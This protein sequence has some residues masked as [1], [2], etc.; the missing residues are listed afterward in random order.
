[1]YDFS[2][3]QGLFGG[4]MPQQ[5]MGGLFSQPQGMGL[6]SPFFTERPQQALPTQGFTPT[7]TNAMSP[8]AMLMMGMNPNMPNMVGPTSALPAEMQ[9]QASQLPM[10]GTQGF[11]EQQPQQTQQAPQLTQ[12]DVMNMPTIKNPAYG[13]GPQYTALGI[14]F[15]EMTQEWISP[16]TLK[17]YERVYGLMGGYG[18]GG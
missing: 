12:K 15:P 1:M 3:L 13:M 17:R 4:G 5:G 11:T 16:A 9:P 18:G 14:M 6:S 2:K 10:Y 8:N 7:R